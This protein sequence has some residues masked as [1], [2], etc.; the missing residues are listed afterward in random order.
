M[1]RDNFRAISDRECVDVTNNLNASLV[2]FVGV[3]VNDD[4]VLLKS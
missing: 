4:E 3:G 1:I 2:T